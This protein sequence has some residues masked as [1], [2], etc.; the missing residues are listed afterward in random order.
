MDRIVQKDQLRKLLKLDNKSSLDEAFAGIADALLNDFV[1]KKG[2][3]K[4]YRIL[5]IEFY[6]NQAETTGKDKTITYPMIGFTVGC[7][8]AQLKNSFAPY[9]LP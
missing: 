3:D 2:D 8:L 6:H 5:E 4:T 7:F 9:K 1:I